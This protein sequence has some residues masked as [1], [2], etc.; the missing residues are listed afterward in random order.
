MPNPG[1]LMARSSRAQLAAGRDVAGSHEAPP[2]EPEEVGLGIGHPLH[3][4]TEG[5]LGLADRGDHPRELAGLEREWMIR[6]ASGRGS[7]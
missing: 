5:V 7:G 2:A 3:A 1:R 6:T 4:R